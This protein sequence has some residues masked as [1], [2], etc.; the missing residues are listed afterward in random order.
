MTLKRRWNLAETDRGWYYKE[1]WVDKFLDS[2]GAF[3]KSNESQWCESY[4]ENNKQRK[5]PKGFAK[6]CFKIV[7]LILPKTN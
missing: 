2:K 7:S 6:N 5:L 4:K 1:E 3:Y